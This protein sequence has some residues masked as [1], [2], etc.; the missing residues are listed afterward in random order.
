MLQ[1]A[2]FPVK[3][4]PAVGYPLDDNQDVTLLD[5]TGYKFIV[6]EDTGKVLSC[7]TNSYKLV[8]NETIIN[9]ANPLIKKL[10]GELK[11]VNV[12][13]HGAKTMM[14]WKFPKEKV[15]FSKID[16][17]IPE[18]NIT[19]SYDGTVGLNIMAGAFRLI[20]LNGAVIGIVVSKYRNK[21]ISSN[22]S[23]DDI[24]DIVEATV[25][26]TKLVFKDEFP[27]LAETNFK[28]KHM[29]DFM[30]MFPEHTNTLITDK[31]IANNPKTFWDL[32]NVGTNVLTHHMNRGLN[33]THSI[34]QRLYPKIKKLA[35][36]EAK[37]AIA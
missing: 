19:N 4:V 29:L 33:S 34:E 13:N 2:K 12:L 14:S 5:K 18:I 27:V 23:L 25:D 6:R 28:E 24:S 21:H 31:I 7:M 11:E 16:E 37:V 3:E 20:C 9:K 10:G 1:N 30:K 36:K 15:K 26:K 35:Y 22:M 8:K 32:F 17:M